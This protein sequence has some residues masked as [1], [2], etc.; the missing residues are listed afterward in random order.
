MIGNTSLFQ[1]WQDIAALLPYVGHDEQAAA[2]DGAAGGLDTSAD[3]AL[4]H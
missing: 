3:L 2:A 1:V 4:D